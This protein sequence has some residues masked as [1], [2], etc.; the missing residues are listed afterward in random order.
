V[1][2]R[3]V[4]SGVEGQLLFEILWQMAYDN[5]RGMLRVMFVGT[6][7]YLG[8]IL[9]LRTSGKR[10]L[11]KMNAFDL[12][13]TVA[14]GSTLATVLLTEDVAL[15]EGLLGFAVLIGLQYMVAWLSVRSSRVRLLVKA[16]PTMLFYRGSFLWDAMRRERVTE[17]EVRAA[18]REARFAA[19]EDVEAV[20][21]ETAGT[22]A[23]VQAAAP[24]SASALQGVK[25]SM[26][27]ANLS[28]GPDEEH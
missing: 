8:L 21:L 10:T 22:F 7:A 1:Q 2:R 24:D 28:W 15:L 16:E 3:S 19:M 25:S 27:D 6:L 5:W 4:K 11:S 14:H 20:V 18:V 17:N 23:V 26:A 9:L 12:V 13:V